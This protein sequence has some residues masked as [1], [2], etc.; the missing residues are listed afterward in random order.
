MGASL[1]P[2]CLTICVGLAERGQRRAEGPLV[3]L[4]QSRVSIPMSIPADSHYILARCKGY[5]TAIPFGNVKNQKYR[6]EEAFPIATG[7][8][9][10]YSALQQKFTDIDKAQFAVSKRSDKFLL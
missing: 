10:I 9:E 5:R 8:N 6:F 4:D 3:G 7:M 1:K 2:S